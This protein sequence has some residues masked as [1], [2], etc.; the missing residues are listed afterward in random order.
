MA[1]SPWPG[2]LIGFF[3]AL[4]GLGTLLFA[5]NTTSATVALSSPL[6]GA[7]LLTDAIAIPGWLGSTLAAAAAI[8]ITVA[9]ARA[10]ANLIG[11]LIQRQTEAEAAA[12]VLEERIAARTS[13]LQRAVREAESA[14]RA[15]SLFLANMSHELRTPLNAIIGFTEIVEE[16]LVL[17]DT[18]ESAAHLGQ[19]RTSAKQLLTLVNDVL[20]V[21]N[22]GV[23]QLVLRE[24]VI[25]CVLL[26]Q[27]AL[28]VVAP[29]AA[30][31]NTSCH[32]LVSNDAQSLSADRTRLKQCLVN[33]LLNAAKFTKDGHIT[34]SVHVSEL[35]G[36]SAIAFEVSDTGIGISQEIQARLFEPFF[37]ADSPVTGGVGG[38]GLG[39]SITRWLARAMG[40]DVTMQ[41]ELG[42]GSR[43]T[44][45]VPHD[46]QD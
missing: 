3:F 6:V 31:A 34:L 11:E 43:F 5:K 29:L 12:A 19:V 28:D 15:K 4:S 40:G 10:G 23:R 18:T 13:E 45:L 2:P 33:L 16:D 41:S 44:L 39:L 27:E 26:A 17:G 22:V 37:Q 24:E 8:L 7:A 9:G 25:A 21:S 36:D 20:D 46:Q 32:L 14:N 30:A 38:A 35:A 1:F 42:V